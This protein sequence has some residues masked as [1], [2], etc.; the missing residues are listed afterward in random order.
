MSMSMRIAIVSVIVIGLSIA[1]GGFS[2]S[3]TTRDDINNGKN[4]SG[5]QMEWQVRY[6]PTE[7]VGKKFPKAIRPPEGQAIRLRISKV[8]SRYFARLWRFKAKT[9]GGYELAD[10][11][12]SVIPLP[13]QLDDEGNNSGRHRKA[14]K[15]LNA[16]ALNDAD[17]NPTGKFVTINGIW[18]PG[19]DNNARANDRIQ[20]KL[21]ISNSSVARIMAPTTGGD[22]EEDPDTDV[23]E[24]TDP[25]PGD[26]DPPPP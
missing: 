25:P 16:V 6:E 11:T 26:D 2:Q 4:K 14:F 18:Q 15:T 22:C 13:V 10:K 21:Y 17:G 19:I 12:D 8:G 23:L 1:T 7:M 3:P 20:L 24:E 9:G 5:K